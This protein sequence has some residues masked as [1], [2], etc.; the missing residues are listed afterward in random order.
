MSPRSRPIWP[1][2]PAGFV[3]AML[4]GHSALGLAF[5]F[6]IYLVCLSGSLSVFA[7][8][9][10]RWERPDTPPV[11]QAAPGAVQEAMRQAIA[12]TPG[13]ERLFVTLPQPLAPRMTLSA[14][15]KDG[16]EQTWT[17]D[18]QGRPVGPA[19]APWT[20]FLTQLHIYLHLPR[21][22]GIFVV[23]LTGVALLSSLISGVLS[24]PRV[25][26]DA[27]HLRWGGARRLQEADLHNRLGVWALPFHVTLSLTGALLGLATVI[28]GVLALVV[29][30][31]DTGKAYALFTAPE[32]AADARPAP[33]PDL[34]AI[35]ARIAAVRPGST[36]Q[37]LQVENPGRGGQHIG[38]GTRSPDRLA[39]ELFSFDGRGRMLGEGGYGARNFGERL[40]SGI[41][42][43]HFGWF[44]GRLVQFAYAALGLALTAVTVGGV[45]I[46]LA[47]RRDRGRPAPRWERVWIAA[48]WSQPLAYALAACVAQVLPDA[49]LT[50]LWLSLTLAALV[51]APFCPASGLSRGLRYSAAV[52][53]AAA[54]VVHVARHAATLRDP[55]GWL[56]DAAFL[57]LAATLATV[58]QPW[59][60]AGRRPATQEANA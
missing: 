18:A 57:A 17:T 4:A 58:G 59:P 12:R 24:H 9:F 16:T 48:V 14:Y 29:F 34:T 31:G 36:I 43:V 15:R 33:L 44:G 50:G 56:V 47:R 45:S 55:M 27:F 13:L 5:A 21:T 32:P 46:W 54:V 52:A 35:Q 30:R 26:R 8:E 60:G 2:I 11:R 42:T 20:E 41:G 6:L 51:A 37:F 10:T 39:R 28:V 25:F 53:L 7:Q 1:K 49:P 38:V 22:W 40:Y 19:D 3:R 23:G